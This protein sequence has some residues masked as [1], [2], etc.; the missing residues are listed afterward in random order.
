MPERS[1]SAQETAIHWEARLF[2][3]LRI[4]S[5]TAICAGNPD[6]DGVDRSVPPSHLQGAGTG[7]HPVHLRNLCAALSR[8]H[9]QALQMPVLRRYG[10]LVTVSCNLVPTQQNVICT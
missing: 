5:A 8:S 1:S 7:S 9:Y 3:R 4:Q 10:R 6:C 2:F